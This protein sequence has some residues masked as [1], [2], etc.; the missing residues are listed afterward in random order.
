MTDVPYPRQNFWVRCTYF[1]GDVRDDTG[2]FTLLPGTH[3]QTMP[4]RRR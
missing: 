2:P 4:A 1:L 3:L